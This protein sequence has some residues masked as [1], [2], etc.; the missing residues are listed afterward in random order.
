[1]S[2]SDAPSGKPQSYTR[3]TLEHSDEKPKAPEIYK[4]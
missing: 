4:C 1:M 2:E 3:K